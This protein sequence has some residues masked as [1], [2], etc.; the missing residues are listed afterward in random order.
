VSLLHDR[1]AETALQARGPA[2]RDLIAAEHRGLPADELLGWFRR[3]RADLLTA[4]ATVDPKARIPWYGTE[5][6]APSAITARLMETWAHGQDAWTSAATSPGRGWR[7]PRPSPAC[8]PTVA[9]AA[10]RGLTA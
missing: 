3:A 6:A 2:F 5:M 1:E 7:S 10:S 9:P 8:R 4:Y